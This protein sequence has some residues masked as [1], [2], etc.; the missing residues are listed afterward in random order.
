[1]TSFSPRVFEITDKHVDRYSYRYKQ[2]IPMEKYVLKKLN[3]IHPPVV[4]LNEVLHPFLTKHCLTVLD[5]FGFMDIPEIDT[6]III[7]RLKPAYLV[8]M[9]DDTKS[10]IW[11]PYEQR[12]KKL[13]F[14]CPMSKYLSYSEQIETKSLCAEI[15]PID[16]S[17]QTKPWSCHVNI[18]LLVPVNDL[19][20]LLSRG[21]NL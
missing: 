13:L 12:G 17:L 2:R 9:D 3:K 21:I 5:T 11:H 7:R 6:P 10:L 16:W 1:M 18:K 8:D 19:A 20:Y 4:N 15:R 14:D